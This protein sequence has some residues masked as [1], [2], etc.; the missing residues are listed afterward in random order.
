[1]ADALAVVPV[2]VAVVSGGGVVARLGGGLAGRSYDRCAL[3]GTKQPVDRLDCSH[4]SL[5]RRHALLVVKTT[6]TPGDVIASH[7]VSMP[8]RATRCFLSELNPPMPPA[9]RCKNFTKL[10]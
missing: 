4:V 5:A 6:A 7:V 8:P 3:A 2:L 9:W 1:V 10:W